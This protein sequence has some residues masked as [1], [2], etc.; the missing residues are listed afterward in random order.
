MTVPATM[1]AVVI[2]V[3][4]GAEVLQHREVPTPRPGPGEVL[5]RVEAVG[6]NYL[7]IFVRRGMPGKPIPLPHISGADIAGVVAAVGPEVDE[8]LVGARVLVDPAVGRGAIGEDLPGGMAEYAVAPAV[9]LIPL[10]AH[11]PFEEAACLPI[12]YGT[13]WR[14]LITRAALRAGETVF[15][16]GASGGVGTGAVQIAKLAGA[17]VIAGTGSPA[18]ADRLRAIGADEVVET[19]GAFDR[20]LWALT[21]K[22]GVD[23]VVNYTGGDTWIP[24]LRALRR[25]GRLVTVGATA[26]YESLI[27]VRYVWVRELN[28]LGSD[29]W[30]PEELRTLCRVTWEG[31]I[32]PV[33][34]RVL[35]LSRA[36][37]GEEALER[38]EVFGKVI[39]RP[40]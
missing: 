21:G 15:I 39:L 17:R 25:G 22:Q 18:K 20:A 32:R 38:R 37:E 34:D 3:H 19:N 16:L 35:P 11:V 27:D 31:R 12:A 29:G 14:M 26:G 2:P 40:N 1:R 23:L 5:V 33:I 8:R 36:A 10:P 28:L 7:D 24:C 4:G 13:A 30:T 6:L 9:N